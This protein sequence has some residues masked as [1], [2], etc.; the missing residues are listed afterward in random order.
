MIWLFSS[1]DTVAFAA[2]SLFSKTILSNYDFDIKNG[3]FE[4]KPFEA[5]LVEVR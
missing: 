3:E 1:T 2:K 5:L 4:L